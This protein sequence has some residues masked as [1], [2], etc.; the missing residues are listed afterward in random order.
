MFKV[1]NLFWFIPLLALLTF[2]LW[3]PTVADFLRPAAAINNARVADGPA[4]ILSLGDLVF[5]QF[6]KGRQ[7]WRIKASTLYSENSDQDMRLE[8]VVADFFD[9]TGAGG[10]PV[11][12][13]R[14]RSGKARYVKERHLL[15]LNDN[16]VVTMTNGYEMYTDILY[17]REDLGQLH[18]TSGVTI[19]G[20]GLMLRGRKMAY[21]PER[22]YLQVDGQVAA[23]IY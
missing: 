6:D 13:T 7:E 5:S 17:Y 22:K 12:A 8:D 18:A 1:K 10:E 11:P 2:P 23:E 16:V 9:K 20:Q 14:I 19:I 21:D 3:R 15:T 4:R